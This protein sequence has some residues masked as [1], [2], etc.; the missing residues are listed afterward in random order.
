MS[1]PTLGTGLITGRAGARR[2]GTPRTYEQRLARHQTL[3]TNNTVS[4]VL[5]ALG[6]GLVLVAIAL[7]K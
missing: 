7:H 3:Q 6:V 1:L 5:L 4:Y 2:Y